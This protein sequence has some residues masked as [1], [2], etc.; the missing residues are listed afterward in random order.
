MEL[1]TYIIHIQKGKKL[2]VMYMQ[3]IQ[4]TEG[5]RT[6]ECVTQDP[7][8]DQI[9]HVPW[10]EEKMLHRRRDYGLPL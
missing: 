7:L 9:T 1:D 5:M 3:K 4:F 6:H 2:Y 8:N 10:K